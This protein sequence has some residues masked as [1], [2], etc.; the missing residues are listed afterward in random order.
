M[1]KIWGRNDGSNVIKALWCLNELGVEYE[2]ID[3]GGEYGGNDDPEYRRKNPMGRLPTLEEEDGFTL[4]E[5]GAVVRYLCGRYSMGDMCPATLRGR[6]E[7]EKWM[8]WSSLNL[9]PFNS[10][11]LQH[12]WR[13]PEAERSRDAIEAAI[14]QAIPMFDILDAHLADRD[15]MCGEKFT[16]A[17]IPAGV[18]THRWINWSPHRPSHPN[19]E[20]WHARLSERPAYQ[21]NVI[22][23]TRPAP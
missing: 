14:T 18:L 2:R 12:F 21:D 22:A 6:A 17:D 11:Y 8:D 10:V 5:S 13:L 3:W 1:L 15:Y 19:V 4:W 9:A 7:A 23:V 16:M 20:A